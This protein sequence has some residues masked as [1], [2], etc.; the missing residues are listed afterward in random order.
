MVVITVTKQDN[1]DFRVKFIVE[2]HL[3]NGVIPD[4]MRSPQFST[5]PETLNILQEAA[6]MNLS[7]NIC[8]SMAGTILELSQWEKIIFD[9]Q[10]PF[11]TDLNIVVQGNF[12]DPDVNMLD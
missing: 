9:Q 2:Y 11:V 7:D 6:S 4:P 3:A 5:G 10:F 1:S 12:N 8:L